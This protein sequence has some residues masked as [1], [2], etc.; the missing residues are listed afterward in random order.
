MTC[1]V[2]LALLAIVKIAGHISCRETQSPRTADKDMRMI[3][4]DTTL[5]G[6][7]FSGSRQGIG[8]AGVI[9]HTLSDF[10]HQLVQAI[11]RVCRNPRGKSL[12]KIPDLGTQRCL[13]GISRKYLERQF[14]LFPGQNTIRLRRYDLPRSND[15]DPVARLVDDKHVRYIPE[16]IRPRSQ[17]V[18]RLDPP[19]TRCWLIFVRGVNLMTSAEKIG[20]SSYR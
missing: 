16:R 3:L 6:K 19:A 8:T 13:G 12:R 10:P 17:P 1:N 11:Q 18:R 14:A 5:G 7:S 2:S 4:A 15:I 20:G 9:I